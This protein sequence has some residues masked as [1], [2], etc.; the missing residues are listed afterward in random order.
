MGY[1]SSALPAQVSAPQASGHIA[2][3]QATRTALGELQDISVSGSNIEAI[4]VLTQA[5]YDALGTKDT[6]TLYVIKG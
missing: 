6:A 1:Y 3:L 5:S 2:I 4:V